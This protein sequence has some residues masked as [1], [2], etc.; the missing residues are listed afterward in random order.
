MIAPGD[1]TASSNAAVR[2]GDVL[3]GKYRVERVLGIGG[4]GTVVAAEHL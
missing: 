4:M 1:G 3:A 2:E